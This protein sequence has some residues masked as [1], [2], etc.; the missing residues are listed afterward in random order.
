MKI[1]KAEFYDAQV[2]N[3]L[4]WFTTRKQAEAYLNS[5]DDDCVDSKQIS[6]C[7]FQPTRKGIVEW[8]SSQ[9]FAETDNG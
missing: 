1:Y 7:E 4:S 3:F 2:G 9:R 8:L 6:V 5:L